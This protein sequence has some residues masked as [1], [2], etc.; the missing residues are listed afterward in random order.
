MHGKRIITA[1]WGFMATAA[2]VMVSGCSMAEDGDV[3]NPLDNDQPSKPAAADS[4]YGQHVDWGPC[5]KDFDYYNKDIDYECGTVE[6]PVDYDHPNDDVID[7]YM[8]KEPA[9][10]PHPQGSLFINPGGPGSSGVDFIV[11]GAG[12]FVSKDV[13]EEFDLIGFDPRGVGRSDPIYCL[14]DKQLEA[15]LAASYPLTEQGVEQDV[16]DFAAYGKACMKHSPQMTQFADTYSTAR[17]LD[18]MR[19]AVGDAKLTFLGYSYGSYMGQ[20]YADQFP[21]R[22]GRMVLDGVLSSGFA[23]DEVGASQ[24]RGLE[25]SYREWVRSC[26]K[27][28]KLCPFKGLSEEDAIKKTDAMLK[29][30][31]ANPMPT[32]DPHRPL[33]QSHALT[34]MIGPLYSQSSWADLYDAMHQAMVEHDG[35]KLLALADQYNERNPDG[36]FESNS[37]EA[38]LVINS[39][40]YVPEGSMEQWRRDAKKLDSQAPLMGKYMSWGSR[41]LQAWPVKAKHPRH[42]VTAKDAPPIIL[43]GN[44][45]DPATPYEMALDAHKNMPSTVLISTDSWDHTAYGMGSKCV[46]HNVDRY[47]IHGIAPADDVD[48]GSH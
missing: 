38:F 5:P 44:R 42:V 3:T 45:H 27:N 39:L 48:C 19:D 31:L 8:I 15:S 11:D 46:A 9:L 30:L 37:S 23:Y 4:F 40:D 29:D 18:I 13:R 10:R 28:D 34:G 47:F 21:K 14:D 22:V 7:I 17:D 20:V 26:Q 24:A 2:L 25:A 43:V 36:T 12:T 35:T 41:I 16:A 32:K 33:T 1:A 6:V